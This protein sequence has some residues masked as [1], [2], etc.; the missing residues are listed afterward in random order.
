M[1]NQVL[2][3]LNQKQKLLV[4]HLSGLWTE[5]LIGPGSY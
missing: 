1:T 5:R 3:A 2:W 4:G